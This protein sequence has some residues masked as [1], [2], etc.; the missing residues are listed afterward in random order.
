M[1]LKLY[2]DLGLRVLMVVARLRPDERMTLPELAARLNC[3]QNHVTKVA[4]YMV[5]LGWLTTVRGRNGGMQLAM[6]ADQYR[7][8]DVVRTLEGSDPLIDCSDPPC[9]FCGRC[10]LSGLLDEAR[11]AFYRTL[12]QET[13]ASILAAPRPISMPS[14]I[15]SPKEPVREAEES[16]S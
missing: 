2:T 8:G 13:F 11:E 1:H 7:I 3:S 14:F 15:R 6:P 10:A 12:N 5:R 4:N 9:P 16:A